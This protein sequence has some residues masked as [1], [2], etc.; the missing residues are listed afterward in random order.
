MLDATRS[1]TQLVNHIGRFR[2]G[3]WSP[4]VKRRTELCLLDSLACFSAGLDLTHF[5]PSLQVAKALFGKTGGEANLPIKISPFAAAFLYGQAANA[6]DYDDTLAGH[7]GAPIIGAVL[8]IAMRESLPID[9]VLRGIAAGYEAHWLLSAAGLPSAERSALVRGNA[10]WDT[11]SASLGVAIALAL[12]DEMVERVLG[13]AVSHSMLPQTA[14]WYERPVPMM[15]NNYG[16]AA[17][18]A[19]ISTDLALAGQTGIT[20]PLEGENGMWRMVGSDRWNFVVDPSERPAVMR[21]GFKQFSVCWHMQEYLKAF[22]KLLQELNDGEDVI[23]IVQ[24][25]PADV[26]KFCEKELAGSAD[27]AFSYPATFSLL[28]SKVDPGPVWDSISADSNLLRYRYVFQ[29][30]QSSTRSIVVHTN[31]GRKLEIAVPA[32]DQYDAASTGLDEQGVL[33]K[34]ARL[35]DKCLQIEVAAALQGTDEEVPHSFYGVLEGLLVK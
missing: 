29:Y 8:A 33:L 10:V 24:H 17:A 13:V 22:S 6:L 3:A 27:I 1:A 20:N 14:K 30:E 35:T 31:A 11:V 12:T 16:W 28:V 7:P 21:T 18:G 5:A 32:N 4:E 15:K 9:R 26:E 23:G 19:V 2:D 25:G 34:H